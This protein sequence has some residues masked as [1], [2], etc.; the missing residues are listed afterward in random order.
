VVV[1][2]GESR[3]ESDQQAGG[4]NKKIDTESHGHMLKML[5][6]IDAIDVTVVVHPHRPFTILGNKARTQMNTINPQGK[7][8][9]VEGLDTHRERQFVPKRQSQEF[10]GC[11][12]DLCKFIDIYDGACQLTRTHAVT[13]YNQCR[14]WLGIQKSVQNAISLNHADVE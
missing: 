12:C 3:R 4:I 9:D 11:L 5:D 13:L 7:Q 1:Q 14:G 6:V 8:M 2:A 10:S